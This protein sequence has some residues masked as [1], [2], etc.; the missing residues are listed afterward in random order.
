M[1]V[2]VGARYVFQP[3][4]FDICNPPFGAKDDKFA[5]MVM[6][7]SLIPAGNYKEARP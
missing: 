2:R 1:K 3:V 7:A 6:C 4:L 5:G